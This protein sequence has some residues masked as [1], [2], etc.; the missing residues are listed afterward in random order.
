MRFAQLHIDKRHK[1]ASLNQSFIMGTNMA[2]ERRTLTQK[3][4]GISYPNRRL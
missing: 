4:G 3:N 2:Q 1:I